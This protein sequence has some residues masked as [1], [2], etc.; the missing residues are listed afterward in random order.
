MGTEHFV[1]ETKGTEQ[2]VSETKGTGQPEAQPLAGARAQL[3]AQD[4]LQLGAQDS[5]QLSAQPKANETKGSV[6]N[7]SQ[8]KANETKSSVPN[9]SETKSSVPNVSETK[10]SVP[11]VSVPVEVQHLS[12]TYSEG[13][14]LA[15]DDISLSLAPGEF[16]GVIGPSGAGKTTL[17]SA[18]AGAIPHHFAG[19]MR[20]AVL[21]DGK[22]TC[23]IALTD[24][25]RMVGSVLQDIDAQMVASNVEDEMLY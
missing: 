6:P 17:A 8:L 12:F 23:D 9:V 10:S 25:S 20:G 5:P 18:L 3:G 7:V 4:S 2:T 15:L 14:R 22:D 1:S 21:V 24:V 13:E 16:L 19:E 11:I